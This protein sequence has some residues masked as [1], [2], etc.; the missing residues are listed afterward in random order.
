MKRLRFVLPAVAIA[1]CY[2]AGAATAAPTS[3]TTTESDTP[4]SVWR[5]RL[6]GSKSSWAS[7]SFTR[8]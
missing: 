3:G 7:A 8:Q 6:R 2:A 5:D 1:A 4:W